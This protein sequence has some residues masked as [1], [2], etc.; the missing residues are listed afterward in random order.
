MEP[1]PWFNPMLIWM[2]G[3]LLGVIGGAFGAFLGVLYARSQRQRRLIGITALR[4]GYFLLLAGSLGLLGAGVA[5]FF[6][7]QPYGIW[8]GLGWPGLM[9]TIVFGALHT[10]LFRL[11]RQMEAQWRGEN[12]APGSER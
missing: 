9:G 6:S 10:I 4:A 2:P 3:V 5:A 11:P 12:P 8:Y 7:G 1:P